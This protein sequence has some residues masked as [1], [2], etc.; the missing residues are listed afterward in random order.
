MKNEDEIRL[1]VAEFFINL[2]GVFGHYEFFT[3]E[4]WRKIKGF[5][6]YDKADIIAA[7][8][9][10][11]F[12]NKYG[13]YTCPCGSCWFEELGKESYDSYIK[14]YEQVFDYFSKWCEE[15]R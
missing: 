12:H 7:F 1:E 14:E 2:S 6:E 10:Y 8:L 5:K 3:K 13:Y 9:H 4:L 11:W 15:Q